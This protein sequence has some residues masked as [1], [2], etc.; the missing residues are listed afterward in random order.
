MDANKFTTRTQEAFSAAVRH[1]ASA[2][3]SQVDPVH[4]LLAL[5]AQ[6]DGTARPLLAAA[7]ADPAAVQA[8]TEALLAKLPV[9]TG[10]TVAAPAM[11]RGAYAA[12]QV[13]EDRATAL[14]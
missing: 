8:D 14:G 13:A 3:H 10:N 11:S 2:G 6:P 12:L 4:L 5:L 9:A 1:A 7:G